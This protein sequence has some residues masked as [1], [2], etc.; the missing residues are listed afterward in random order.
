MAPIVKEPESK[1][2][3]PAYLWVLA[4]NDAGVWKKAKHA[5]TPGA[6]DWAHFNLLDEDKQTFGL[7]VETSALL[8][9]VKA[10]RRSASGKGGHGHRYS[11]GCAV[12]RRVP[13]CQRFGRTYNYSNCWL[14]PEV[15]ALETAS[16]F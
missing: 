10:N 4:D 1:V 7:E 8:P 3:P 6:R 13:I 14:Y 9:I 12:W 2:D 11:R 15:V 16:L 5:G